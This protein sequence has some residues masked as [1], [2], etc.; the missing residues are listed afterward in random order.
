MAKYDGL[1]ITSANPRGLTA[2]D[3]AYNTTIQASGLLTLN[4]ASAYTTLIS[5]TNA[6]LAASNG[7]VLSG[8]TATHGGLL[9]VISP[10]GT[11]Q[12]TTVTHS[13]F[14]WLSGGSATGTV[15]SDTG[16]ENLSDGAV[17]F[18]TVINADG[19]Q[20]V[21]GATVS[22]A[23]LSGLGAIVSWG[24]GTSRASASSA[25]H[26]MLS[27]GAKAFD[28]VVDA[29]GIQAVSAGASAVNVQIRNYGQQQVLAGGVASNVVM[30][31]GTTEYQATYQLVEGTVFDTKVYA[32]GDHYVRF[33]GVTHHSEIYD[34]AWQTVAEGGTASGTTIY[35]GGLQGI[36]GAGSGYAKGAAYDTVV[37][38][39]GLQAVEAGY[40]ERTTVFGNQQIWDLGSAVGNT[41][42]E[43]GRQ[44][45]YGKALNN[46]ILAGGQQIV[47]SGTFT[48]SA[49]QSSGYASGNTLTSAVQWVTA[50]GT[51]QDNVF[52]GGSQILQNGSALNN[53]LL[54][55]DQ[56][57]YNGC[58]SA[59]VISGGTQN[60]VSAAV[61]SQTV[62]SQGKLIV[63]AGAAAN[64]TVLYGGTHQIFDGGRAFDTELRQDAFMEVHNTAVLSGAVIH[65]GASCRLYD[66]AVWSGSVVIAGQVSRQSGNSGAVSVQFRLEGAM[67]DSYMLNLHAPQ[68]TY[69][70]SVARGA[71]NGTQ[72]LINDVGTFSQTTFSLSTASAELGTL[73]LGT[74]AHFG[75]RDYLVTSSANQLRLTIS[76]GAARTAGGDIDGNGLSDLVMTHTLQGFAG[77]WLI[78]DD[79]TA[80]W[81]N[82]STLSG[83][84]AVFG[85]GHVTPGTCADVFL[86]DH[87]ANTVGAWIVGNDGLVSGW[88]TIGTFDASTEVLGLGDFNAD[89]ITDLLLR[90]T[91]GAVGCYYADSGWHYFQSLGDEWTIAAVGDLNGDGR[92][93]VVLKHDAGFAGSWLC[94]ADG[95]MAWANLDTLSDDFAIAG[96]GD[97]NGDGVDDVLLRRGDYFGA[98]IVEDGSAKSWMGLGT[99]SPG[100]ELEDIGDFN[101]DGVD[102][103]RIR[104]SAGDLGTLCV[105]G[106]SSLEWHYYGSV[107]AEWTTSLAASV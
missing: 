11:V 27:A 52:Y 70:I 51:A 75:S 68:A 38:F 19:I 48:S 29:Y 62:I 71:S 45:V 104:S 73:T 1:I 103:L 107:G 76:G 87:A 26:Q 3:S 50:G 43:G 16:I 61:A 30:S 106:E 4:G 40:A 54:Q 17:E 37:S 69:S 91:N 81:G 102:D 79:Q 41:I 64:G 93:D 10:S 44:T 31:S 83:G 36:Y 49:A 63:N 6:Y 15:L 77:A 92:S 2:G 74:T 90:N 20:Q 46:T 12:A 33:G 57:V 98:W 65:S 18:Q 88:E 78:Q 89:G 99:L 59:T 72:I 8:T 34:L 97:F 39:G 23:V 85:T 84:W 25:G 96:A 35:S 94:Q 22:G 58:V 105:V 14:F 80:A 66:G 82:L 95:T 24:D 9:Q 100:T 7:A 13:S 67:T 53:T 21:Q 101:G 56:A 60:L 28:T 55:A 42:A 47:G 86:Y 32:Y 5:G